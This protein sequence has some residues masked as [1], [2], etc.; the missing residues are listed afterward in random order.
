MAALKVNFEMKGDIAIAGF[1]LTAEEWQAFDA[2]ARAQL[3]AAV[4]RRGDGAVSAPLGGVI[5][6]PTDDETARG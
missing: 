4:A 1:L 6:E 5:S 3:I 2:D